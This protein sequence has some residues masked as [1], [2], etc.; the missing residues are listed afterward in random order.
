MRQQSERSR[1]ANF[2]LMHHLEVVQSHIYS[3]L[4]WANCS[5]LSWSEAMREPV[6]G[7]SRSTDSHVFFIYARLKSE[8]SKKAM[9]NQELVMKKKLLL[10]LASVACV[11][12]AAY[13]FGKVELTKIYDDCE[14]GCYITATSYKCGKCKHAMSSKLLEMGSYGKAK[15][16]FYCDSCNH[17]SSYWVKHK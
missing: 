15:M 1:W 10:G 6:R 12:I 3:A 11:S 17:S 4:A 5:C 16:E 14:K 2:M 9:N 8:E 7:I 13:A